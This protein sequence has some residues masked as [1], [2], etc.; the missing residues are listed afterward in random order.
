MQN[1]FKYEKTIKLSCN[2]LFVPFVDEHKKKKD[3][4]KEFKKGN[5]CKKCPGKKK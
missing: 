5:R 1:E 3:C 4:C 2:C